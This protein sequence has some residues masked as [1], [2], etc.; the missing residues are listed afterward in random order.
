M[1]RGVCRLSIVPVRAEGNHRAEMVTQLLFGDHYSVLEVSADKDWLHIE[2]YFDG[3]QGWIDAKQHQ[4]I[5]EEYFEQ[6]NHSDYKINLD[7]TSGILFKKFPLQ[8]MLGSILPIATNELF[9]M[10]EQLAFNGDSKSLGQKRDFEFLKS[11]AMKFL[12]APYLWGGK[13][14][15]GVDCSGFTQQVFKIAGYKLLRDA[16]Q[17]ARQGTEVAGLDQVKPGDLA[18]FTNHK[19]KVSHVG[20]MLEGKHIIHASGSVR[21]D[22]LDEQGIRQSAT[23]IYSHAG[24]FFRRITEF[25]VS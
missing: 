13:T 12:N 23:G 17:Q 24:G 16:S 5:S 22:L 3:Y 19:G 20:I 25:E 11:I 4:Q 6:I 15:F 9:K 18:F 14:P 7:I 8:I 2:V 10:E 21:V 1:E